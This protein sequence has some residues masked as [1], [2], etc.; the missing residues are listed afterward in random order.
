MAYHVTVVCDLRGPDCR[1]GH[2]APPTGIHGQVDVAGNHASSE[3]VGMGWTRVRRK[4]A[5]PMLWCCPS[6]REAFSRQDPR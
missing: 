4:G 3:A 1:N 2:A 5:G 6:C